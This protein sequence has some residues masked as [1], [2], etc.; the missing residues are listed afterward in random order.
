[1]NS[2]SVGEFGTSLYTPPSCNKIFNVKVVIYVPPLITDN[3][4]SRD[5]LASSPYSELFPTKTQEYAS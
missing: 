3:A 4:P 2:K 1:M 5:A